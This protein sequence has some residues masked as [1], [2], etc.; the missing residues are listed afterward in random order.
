MTERA[1]TD[2]NRSL[3]I[4]A[5]GRVEMLAGEAPA[6]DAG[7]VL[8]ETRRTLISTGT[9]LTFFE[10]DARPDSVWSEIG[11]LPRA[12][13]YSHVGAVVE[14]GPG[15]DRTWI[16]RRVHSRGPH[17]AWVTRAVDKLT[18][19]VDGVTDD[20]A[21]LATLASVAM[22]GLRRVG[23]QW[24][25]SAAVF[26]LGLVGQLT[27]RL[28]AALGAGPIFGVELSDFRL[29]ALPDRPFVHGLAGGD[30]GALGPRIAEMN[31]GRRADV[32]IETT[33]EPDLIPGQFEVLRDQGRFLMLSSP[34]GR[35]A[36]DFHDL[37]NR[38]SITIVG[39]H[40]S[41][42]PDMS[43]PASPWSATRHD[44]LF[45]DWL[46][47]GRV[48]VRELIS[49]RFPAERAADAYDLLAERRGEALGVILEWS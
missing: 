38:R 25:E 4:T 10:A 30:V 39:A 16:G 14:T 5:P 17:A 24:G 23:L 18:P 49:H 41:S 3:W 22:N 27:V 37:C 15:V 40:G 21:T 48:S 11:R 1:T 47:Q 32:V 7:E 2:G 26:G 36:F 42:H 13:G 43:T 20:E 45:L 12:I 9:E 8:I 6:P 28:A 46:A 35:T 44:E 31:R 29:R 34:R 19:V 33:A